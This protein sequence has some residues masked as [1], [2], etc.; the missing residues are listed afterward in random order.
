M[1]NGKLIASGTP[2][3]II[4]PEILSAVY[5]IDMATMPHP[6]TGRPIGF[7]R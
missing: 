4:T 1:K 2:A 5:D 7:I 3:E 6:T